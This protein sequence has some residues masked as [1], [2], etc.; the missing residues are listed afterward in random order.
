MICPGLS[1]GDRGPAI[2]ALEAIGA[3]RA[4]VEGIQMCTWNGGLQRIDITLPCE[5]RPKLFHAY[6]LPARRVADGAAMHS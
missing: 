1:M 5:C 6:E 4:P 2:L 3:Q